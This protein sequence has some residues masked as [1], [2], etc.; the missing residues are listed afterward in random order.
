MSWLS[1]LRNAFSVDVE[2]Y[3]QVSAFDGH[4]PRHQWD[5][6]T[7]RVVENTRRILRLLAR[8]EIRATFFVLGWVAHKFPQ[9]VKEIHQDGHEI[10]SHSYWHRLVYRMTPDEFREDLRLSCDVVSQ[11][12]GSAVT[13]YRAPS[14]SITSRSL[15]ALEILAEEKFELDSSI[16]PVYHDRYGI[17]NARPDIHRIRLR[18]GELV[19][20]PPAVVRIGP[21]RLPVG[22]GGYFRLYPMALSLRALRR[23]NMREGRPFVFYIHPWEI[24]PDQP[25]LRAGSLVA[26]MR[27]YA[28]LNA[29]EQK[30][31]RLFG[32]FL[33][34]PV[35]E[36]A[37]QFCRS[38]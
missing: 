36:V 14:F 35:G 13:L 30:L 3:F 32:E 21:L 7:C 33:F 27:H 20:F 12:T 38:P 34:A 23:I 15:W 19:E 28:N 37:K 11:V 16:F 26:R 5:S 31:R 24:D 6:Y 25:R 29:T 2:D 18:T 10:G 4:I 8:H 17:P 1:Q 9:L 22:G